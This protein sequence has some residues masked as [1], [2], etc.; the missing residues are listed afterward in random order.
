MYTPFS[1]SQ[2]INICVDFQN[3]HDSYSC[4]VNPADQA[5]HLL[6]EPLEICGYRDHAL[7]IAHM[8]IMSLVK[9]ASFLPRRLLRSVTLLRPHSQL[10]IRIEPFTC[11]LQELNLT[12]SSYFCFFL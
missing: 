3:N 10:K 11:T 4:T 7:Y 6:A 1:G 12:E 5:C 8:Q 9:A 2:I